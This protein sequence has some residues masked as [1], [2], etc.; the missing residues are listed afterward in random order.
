MLWRA[1]REILL[2]NK[3]DRKNEYLLRKMKEISDRNYELYERNE[4]LE[5]FSDLKEEYLVN[6]KK[7]D[8]LLAE[9]R[10]ILPI[11]YRPLYYLIETNLSQ[12]L[13]FMEY[14]QRI[15][16]FKTSLRID[17]ETPLYLHSIPIVSEVFR[18]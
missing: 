4:E 13:D 16:T 3:Y 10:E 15:D 17:T 9:A 5:D 1:Y 2:G 6:K 8:T 14:R 7:A 11:V 12:I 18:R